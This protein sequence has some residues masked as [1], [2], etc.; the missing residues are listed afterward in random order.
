MNV[1]RLFSAKKLLWLLSC[2]LHFKSGSQSGLHHKITQQIVKCVL[3]IRVYT[4][5][6][7]YY[8]PYKSGAEN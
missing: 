1:I 4:R 7:L 3:S 5:W 8:I 2:I 6:N